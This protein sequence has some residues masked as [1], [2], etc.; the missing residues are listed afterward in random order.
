MF[1]TH[2]SPQ[3]FGPDGL[4]GG[5]E[6]YP[7]ELAKAMAVMT[8]T[9]FVTFGDRRASLRE[10]DLSVEV[11]HGRW[12]WRGSPVNPMA[13]GVRKLVNEAA[14][15]HTHQLESVVTDVFARGG[16][17]ARIPVCVT[18][19]GGVGRNFSRLLGTRQSITAFLPV[20][21]FSLSGYPD[22]RDRAT[23]IGGGVDI[24]RFFPVPGVDREEKVVFVG[25]VLPHKGLDVLIRAVPAQVKLRIFGRCY[26]A[27]YRRDLERLSVGKDVRIVSDAGDA[28]ILH[29]Y[30]TA[31]VSVLPSVYRTMYGAEAPK[32]ELLGLVLLEAM[33]CGTPVIGTRVGGVPETIAHG[34]SGLV[35]EPGDV[36][37]LRDAI[38][39]LLSSP[40][41][42][43][44][45]SDAAVQRVREHFT[46]DEVARRC[47]RSYA[48]LAAPGT[49]LSAGCSV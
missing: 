4:W 47:L 45:L 31:R 21:E 39:R 35:V 11:L 2:I 18:D 9:R 33:A 27:R 15:L 6:R 7:W 36:N 14:V 23:L 43:R 5:G 24:R 38:E 22:L 49:A 34:E 46:W 41:R 8:P 44:E 28:E 42:W 30:R 48:R 1:V 13:F 20:S 19:H 26:N 25:R 40:P 17:R 16:R 29:A 12:H 37:G 32:P 10:G 3:G